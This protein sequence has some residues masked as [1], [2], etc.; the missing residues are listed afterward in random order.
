M[1]WK[2]S[3]NG[4]SATPPD[5][6]LTWAQATGWSGHAAA[7]RPDARIPVL[8]ELAG[9][10]AGLD[11]L[12]IVTSGLVEVPGLYRYPDSPGAATP[13]F[14]AGTVAR[15][16]LPELLASPEIVRLEFALPVDAGV[17]DQV[18]VPQREAS[19]GEVVIGVIDRGCA[20]LNT[21][22]RKAWSG[23]GRE[24]TRIAALW[25]QAARPT[26]PHW[27]RPSGVG[28]GRELDAAA[29]DALIA[30][31]RDGRSEES[32]YQ[33]LGYLLDAKGEVVD[34]AHGTHV[35][36]TFAGLVPN[37]SVEASAKPTTQDAAQACP[38]VFVSIPSLSPGDT[39][40]ASSGAYLLDAVRYILD[41]AGPGARVVINMSLGLHGGPHDGSSPI[42][43]A[44][45]EIL[46]FRDDLAIVVAGGNGAQ[47]YWTTTG[48][49]A[50]GPPVSRVWR[51]MPEDPTDS[52][53]EI[54]S[55]PAA[56]PDVRL[57]PPPGLPA[58]G[59]VGAGSTALLERAPGQP[60]AMLIHLNRSAL[61]GDPMALVCVAP[62]A[63]GRATALEG[64]WEIE[65][66]C[67]TAAPVEFD[68]WIQ[69]DEPP[70]G[71][72]PI[73]SEFAD[74][75]ETRQGEGCEM[76]NLAAGA[77]V[78]A[79]GASRLLDGKASDYSA[80]ARTGVTSARLQAKAAP[81]AD[82]DVDAFGA[83]D[84]SAT[85]IGLFS[86]RVRSGSTRRMGGTSIGA[87]VVA[88][89]VANMLAPGG[90]LART[91]ARPSL[92]AAAI[93][94]YVEAIPKGARTVNG[95]RGYMP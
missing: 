47:E 16:R 74:F 66:S 13:R 59:W 81:M 19:I 26:G 44:L 63:G 18:P 54:W 41:R 68:I 46:Q 39:T 15:D 62:N 58:S 7:G 77:L 88:R 71:D 86:A 40:G 57:T 65:L 56:T 42:D 29:I 80:R 4:G 2:V 73:Q 37:P 87:P 94:A 93:K 36:D 92:S 70:F 21:A 72:V 84:E 85:A 31:Q 67:P 95:K 25:D 6:Y 8:L 10:T 53:L 91:P 43:E 34:S 61:G 82:G 76:N 60:V 75:D 5:P 32:L 1:E 22:L 38:I 78:I 33:S 28:Y 52:F 83:A 49:V 9:T 27:R 55:M 69:R 12:A 48:T 11:S 45:D 14:C 17:V 89:K 64:R 30:E 24:R 79:V 20:F 35:L 50:P 23:P 90:E 51:L 3:S